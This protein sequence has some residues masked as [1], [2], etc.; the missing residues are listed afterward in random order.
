MKPF[1]QNDLK[2]TE[3]E[4]DKLQGFLKEIKL[5]ADMAAAEFYC[6]GHSPEDVEY[7]QSYDEMICAEFGVSYTNNIINDTQEKIKAMTQTL[8]A[9]HNKLNADWNKSNEMDQGFEP[10]R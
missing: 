7:A 10:E 4:F 9:N 1:T 8:D 6:G 5:E 2:T 3:G